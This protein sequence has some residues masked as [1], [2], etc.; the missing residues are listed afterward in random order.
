MSDFPVIGHLGTGIIG[1][2][3]VRQFAEHDAD[4]RIW[5]RTQSRAEA[6]ANDSVTPVDTPSRAAADVDMKVAASVAEWF[7]AALDEH[8]DEDMAAIVEA[9]R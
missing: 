4:V 1:S 5:N 2:A 3:M 9:M 7:E 6:L 8:G